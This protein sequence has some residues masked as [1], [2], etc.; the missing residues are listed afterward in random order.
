MRMKIM[1]L[2]IY[3]CSRASTSRVGGVEHNTAHTDV[4]SVT[5]SNE[6]ARKKC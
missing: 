1:R 5:F 6:E 2:A 3:A 4:Y